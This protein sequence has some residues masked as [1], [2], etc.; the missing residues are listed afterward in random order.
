MNVLGKV[1]VGANTGAL[2]ACRELCD[3]VAQIGANSANAHLISLISSSGLSPEEASALDAF[4]DSLCGG[5]FFEYAEAQG[6]A[7][8]QALRAWREAAEHLN[9][10]SGRLKIE[11]SAWRISRDQFCE[12]AGALAE[13]QSQ[14]EGPLPTLKLH[15]H[16]HVTLS[17]VMQG[18]GA[19]EDFQEDVMV[20]AIASIRF[21]IRGARDRRVPE[22]PVGLT[23]VT[24]EFRRLHKSTSSVVGAQCQVECAQKKLKSADEHYVRLRESLRGEM[25]G[26][27][28]KVGCAALDEYC[29]M[30]S[31]RA[32]V[33]ESAYSYL[34]R[35]APLLPGQSQA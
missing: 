30:L 19:P 10:A 9:V 1:G 26:R 21:A 3:I 4:A 33:G 23:R 25:E 24:E 11:E 14:L 16:D 7:L 6:R 22:V 18:L 29:S 17:D 34:K 13:W 20:N 8:E 15:I 31:R 2:I 28:G 35:D 27:A 5:K 12:A 32:R